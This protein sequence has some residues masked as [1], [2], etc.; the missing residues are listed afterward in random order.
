MEFTD[1]PT[2]DQLQKTMAAVR[3]RGI[4]AELMESPQAALA[5]LQAL[6]PP[7][8]TVSTGAS[9]TLQAIGFEALLK[10]GQHPWRNLRAEILAEKDPA[11]QMA[12]RQQ[13]TLADYY[14]GSVHGIVQTG[15]IVVASATGSQIAPYAYSSRHIIWVAGAQKIVPTLDAAIQ[16]VRQRSLPLEV[17][18]VKKALGNQATTFVGKLMIFEREA[19]YLRRQ[20]TLLLLNEVIGE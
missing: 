6:I 19:P 16:R 13:S 8:A 12:L 15:E 18:R 3:E 20:V 10:S 1:L 9:S 2:P 4:T 11:R 7:G 5:R 17:D 14:L